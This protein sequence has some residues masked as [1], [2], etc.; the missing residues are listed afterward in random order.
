MA[1][2]CLGGR[3]IVDTLL[4]VAPALSPTYNLTRALGAVKR[5]FAL[6]SPKDRWLLGAGTRVFG[7]ID[8]RFGAAA[9]QVGFQLPANLDKIG[10]DSYS[11]VQEVHWSATL[12]REGPSGGHIGWMSERFLAKHLLPI[13]S[14][15]PLIE[16]TPVGG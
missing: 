16:T 12:A 3:R 11:R 2:E 6:V 5:C 7:T 10:R 4:L 13:L 9:G 14:G 15:R 1:C 8:R